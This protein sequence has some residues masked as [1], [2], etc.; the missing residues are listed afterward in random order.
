LERGFAAT[1]TD[2]IAEEAGVSKRTLYAY[3]PNKEV[4]LSDVLQQVIKGDGAA[5]LP[6]Q[7]TITLEQPDQLRP[8]LVN[9]AH[10]FIKLYMQPDYLA[11]VRVIINE[12]PKLPQ[13]GELFR[14]AVP[15]RSLQILI[16]LLQQGQEKGMVNVP[17]LEAAARLYVGAFLTHVVLGGL[18]EGRTPRVPD[19]RHI[20]NIVDL[21]LKA[22]SS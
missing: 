12:T 2:A 4:L 15:E 18:L 1:S 22:I 19:S 9:M 10:E 13:L 7:S 3:Y 16:R 5:W 11:L 20:E 8:L 6:A 14:A 21:Y 17:D